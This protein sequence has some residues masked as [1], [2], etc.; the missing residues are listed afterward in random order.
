MPEIDQLPNNQNVGLLNSN[1]V[2]S[3]TG[4]ASFSAGAV[5]FDAAGNLSA[6][7]LAVN[8]GQASISNAGLATFKDMTING[9]VALIDS[10]GA[11]QFANGSTL[12]NSNGSASFA[13]LALEISN[14]GDLSMAAASKLNI[15][16]GANQ[17][18]G[19]LTLIGGTKTIAN[20]TITAN[21]IIMLTRKTSGGTLGT[22]ITYT[23]NAGVGFTVNSDN[24][25]DTS[26][27]SYL[28]IEVP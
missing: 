15:S 17:R 10:A 22:A 28:L 24:V 2:I 12:L 3:F 7:S 14:V 9:G 4:S 26:T 16:S 13:G 23:L 21:T 5:S 11:A 8:G 18:A 20:T 25:L 19:N 1:W 27:F 6:R